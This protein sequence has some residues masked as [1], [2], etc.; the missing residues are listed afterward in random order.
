MYYN[1]YIHLPTGVTAISTVQLALCPVKDVAFIARVI[2]TRTHEK[3]KYSVPENLVYSA[4]ELLSLNEKLNL[5]HELYT[6]YAKN[7]LKVC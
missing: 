6:R 5:E 7:S 4:F 3:R 1:L 2:T